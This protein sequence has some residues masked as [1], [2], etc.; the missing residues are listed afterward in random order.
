MPEFTQEE[1]NL[2][3][4]YD[5]GSLSGLIYELRS[6]LKVLM[7]D[8]TDLR[9]LTES[10]IYKVEVMSRDDYKK[11]CESW[12]HDDRLLHFSLGLDDESMNSMN[13]TEG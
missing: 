3:Y 9:E 1:L 10:T 13:N 7:P 12:S 4:L 8:E 6:M 5:P 11:M 2:I